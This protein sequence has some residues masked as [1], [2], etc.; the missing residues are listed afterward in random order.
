MRRLRDR[1][2]FLQIHKKYW[3]VLF[4]D[5]A[6]VVKYFER[7]C[8]L[9]KSCNSSFISLIPKTKDPKMIHDFRPIS[10][11]GCIYKIIAKI[12]A[13][14]I[15]KVMGHCIDEVQ[16]IYVE[17]RNILD[18]PLIVNEI[19]SWAKKNKKKVL[20]FK[21]DFDK[22]FDTVNWGFLDANLMQM[23]FCDEWRM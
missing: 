8:R 10:L 22:A 14:R 5:I 4:G 7:Y 19:C 11:I 3:E 16:S 23:D 13:I 17:G 18:G 9:D 21:D 1:R 2:V 6:A 12:L 20:H 15:K